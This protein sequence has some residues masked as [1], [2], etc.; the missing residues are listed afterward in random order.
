MTP[1][2]LLLAALVFRPTEF[3]WLGSVALAV[4]VTGVIFAYTAGLRAQAHSPPARFGL[5]SLRLT[6][7]VLLLA[8]LLH[9]ACIR[10]QPQPERRVVAVVLD[11]SVSMA[12]PAQAGDVQTPSRYAAARA[13]LEKQLA[14]ALARNH[15]VELFD[16]EARALKPDALSST[17]TTPESPL[18][19]T[20]LRVQRQL[21]TAPL[22]A[23]VLLS[24]G[25]ELTDTPPSGPLT[26]LRVPVFPVEV[27]DAAA[28]R[29]GPPNLAIEAVSANQ[30]VIVG[31]TA[32][33]T[34]DLAASGDV[35]RAPVTLS[36]LSGAQPVA[37]TTLTWRPGDT[38]ARAQLEFTP[39][40]PGEFTY[41]VQ[42]QP[43]SGETELSDNRATFPLAVRAKALTVLYLDG[44]LRWE[45]KYVRE[46]L[47]ADA[48]LNL[49]TLVRTV[50][51]GTDRGSQGVLSAEQLARADVVIL[52]DLEATFFS[53]SEIEA[54]R[55]WVLD[56]GGALVLTGGYHSFGAEGFGRTPLR[57]VLPVEFSSDPNPQIEQAFS[58]K[59]TQAGQ[60]HPIFSLT[61]DPVRDAA[62]YNA[63]PPLDG[64]TRIA[65]VK[66][67][68]LVLAVDP[69][70]AGPQ[71]TGGMPVM[72]L[73]RVGS[74]RT[75]VLSV[76]TTWRWRT[77]VGGFTGDSTF[78]QRFW[79]QLV[80][81]LVGYDDKLLRPL[82]VTTGATRVGLGDTL[83][84]DVDLQ[85]P[86][87]T[88]QPAAPYR[89]SALALDEQGQQV[90]VPLTEL[91]AGRY[92]GTLAA[93]QAG[94]LDVQALAE[95]A[96]G[97]GGA[98]YSD[99]TSVT[100]ERPD[101]EAR[102]PRAN[103]Q[104][105]GQVAQITGGRVLRPEDIAAWAQTLPADPLVT[106]RAVD[107]GWRLDYWAGGLCLVALC[108]EWILR[109]L[110]RLV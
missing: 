109:R 40:R 77:V 48:D 42:V 86:T 34:V 21:H 88:S 47:S 98:S 35:G 84:V 16:V 5:L 51:A 78:Y 33:V 41:A 26:E 28:Q 19:D 85:L 30:R 105:L 12:Q 99:A 57:D 17:P 24:D 90:H 81:A 36:V 79:S 10:E 59:L 3:G 43:L 60:Q 56:R 96:D 58:F 103:P 31:N 94:R 97:A 70:V 101:R 100:V 72:T 2:P 39:R 27:C 74:G 6:G 106:A 73:Q 50:P 49:V 32:R 14:P 68:A 54:L 108:A 107:A 52:G 110:A 1:T 22:E 66:P 4:G 37:S 11:D 13:V 82:R 8:T 92:R 102:D 71:G 25:A 91:G 93:R 75:L 65:A 55:T 9:P 63:L 104:W 23:V 45:G 64:C 67:G 7:I 80:R 69:G 15:R 87:T 89:V 44:V 38:R 20:L 18:T 83:T 76:D 29:A 62:F 61:G 53:A 46:A 95:P